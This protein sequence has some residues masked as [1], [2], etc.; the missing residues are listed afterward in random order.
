VMRVA[1]DQTLGSGNGNGHGEKEKHAQTE[2]AAFT[3]E[4]RAKVA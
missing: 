1:K 3:V 2:Q 4:K